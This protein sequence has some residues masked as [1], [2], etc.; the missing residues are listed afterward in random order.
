MIDAITFSEKD[1]QDAKE[2]CGQHNRK[3]P[4]IKEIRAKLNLGLREAKQL[5]DDFWETVDHPE[6]V[7]YDFLDRVAAKP[8]E[9]HAYSLRIEGLNLRI[10]GRPSGGSRA[11]KL[12]KKTIQELKDFGV[13]SI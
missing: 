12:S 9:A 2:I 1:L 11:I 5:M 4:A 8:V 13:P 6:H 10:I 7:D 3:I